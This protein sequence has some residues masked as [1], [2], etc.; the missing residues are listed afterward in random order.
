MSQSIDAIEKSE[1]ERLNVLEVQAREIRNQTDSL[2][3]SIAGLSIR[4]AVGERKLREIRLIM[5]G[6][7]IQRGRERRAA[8]SEAN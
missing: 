7:N 8:G 1:L 2:N 5:R 4:S 6:S 3:D